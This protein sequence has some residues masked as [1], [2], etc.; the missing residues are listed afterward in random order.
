MNRPGEIA[1][2]RA[3]ALLLLLAGTAET[4]V[5]QP[6]PFRYGAPLEVGSFS[7]RRPIPAGKGGVVD[8]TLDAAALAHSRPDFRDLRIAS[9]DG[10]Q[11]PYLLERA[12]GDLSLS[13]P[14]V[15]KDTS[16]GDSGAGRGR[17]SRYLVRLPYAHLPDAQLTLETTARVFRR[18]VWL[19][20]GPADGDDR[21]RAD[22]K[23]VGRESWSHADA[24]TEAPTLTFD[25]G[26][27]RTTT[28]HLS[29][30]EGDNAP[31][32]LARPVLLLPAWHV[33]LVRPAGVPLQLLYGNDRIE[34]PRYDLALVARSILESPAEPVSA[35][36]EASATSP[37]PTGVIFWSALVLAVVGLLALIIRLVGKPPAAS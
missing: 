28:L 32:P 25:L 1:C 30:D 6:P 33:R 2:L 12:S 7:Y 35:G 3:V 22:W 8:L 4:Q 16:R 19:E 31:L 5:P 26:W 15:E 11:V 36:P 37:L 23:I 13:L 14:P 10:R 18:E 21:P 20:T 9:S 29:V 34:A 17:I 27:L 24:E